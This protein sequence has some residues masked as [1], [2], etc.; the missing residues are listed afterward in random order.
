[1][2]PPDLTNIK[3]ECRDFLVLLLTRLQQRLPSVVQLL[4]GLEVLAPQSAVLG[5]SRQPRLVKLPLLRQY[6]G[7][8]AKLQ[9]QWQRLDTLS[10]PLHVLQGDNKTFW[11]AVYQHQDQTGRRDMRELGQFVL[12]L[13]A[14]P[15]SN[16]TAA[17]IFSQIS[18]LL[19][20]WY[21]REQLRTLENSLHIKEYMYRNNI[22][23]NDFVPSQEML[24]LYH[25]MLQDPM[26]SEVHDEST[27]SNDSEDLHD[28][29]N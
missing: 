5:W 7:C 1:M 26:Y 9:D 10:W 20:H 18:S 19:I 15:L 8:L 28:L 16:A 24:S 3:S 17:R 12:S 4:E 2:D 13:M 14:M 21:N 27:A 11:L 23:C 6:G 29:Y 22:C 25:M